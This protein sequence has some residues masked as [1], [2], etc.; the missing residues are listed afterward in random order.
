MLFQVYFSA[1]QFFVLTRQ[2]QT[3]EPLYFFCTC[4][5]DGQANGDS[6]WQPRVFRRF[7]KANSITGRTF[8]RLK[9]EAGEGLAMYATGLESRQ[10]SLERKA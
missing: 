8:E 2:K 4:M 5:R 3:A 6:N 1:I 7:C 9:R 10:T